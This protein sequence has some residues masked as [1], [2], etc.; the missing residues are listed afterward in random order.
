MLPGYL[1]LSFG[2][3]IKTNALDEVGADNGNIA[4][5]VRLKVVMPLT[6]HPRG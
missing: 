6:L 3:D 2:V 1:L 5:R 4:R